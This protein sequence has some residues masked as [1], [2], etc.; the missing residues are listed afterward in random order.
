[1]KWYNVELNTNEAHKLRLFLIDNSINY[2]ASSA[3]N[4]IHFEIE[5][6]DKG[7]QLVNK[8]LEKMWV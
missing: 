2:E 7:Y 3:Y 6:N 4:L 8:F 5:L 1:M